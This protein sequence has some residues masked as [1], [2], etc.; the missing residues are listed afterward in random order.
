M[1]TTSGFS[2]ALNPIGALPRKRFAALAFGVCLP[3]SIHRVFRSSQ[4][5]VSWH[6]AQHTDE[7]MAIDLDTLDHAALKAMLVSTREVRCAAARCLL[8]LRPPLCRR[9][10]LRGRM[11]RARAAQIPRDPHSACFAHHNRC[12]RSYCR[13]LLDRARDLRHPAGDKAIPTP[14]CKAAARRFACLD[15]IAAQPAFPKIRHCGD[16]GVEIDNNAAESALRVVALGRKNSVLP[17]QTVQTKRLRLISMPECGD[18][19]FS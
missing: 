4:G 8:R 13:A 9:C 19:R 12:P 3:P 6:T 2:Q 18:D 10:D 11:L 16:G 15:G 5:L 7:L 1:L 14:A 17:D